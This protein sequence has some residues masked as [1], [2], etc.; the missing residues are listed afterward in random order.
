MTRILHTDNVLFGR[1]LSRKYQWTSAANRFSVT[2]LE[3][4]WTH[5]Q[6]DFSPS[7]FQRPFFQLWKGKVWLQRSKARNVAD[8]V[9]AWCGPLPLWNQWP[10][11]AVNG[12]WQDDTAATLLVIYSLWYLPGGSYCTRHNYISSP[13]PAGVLDGRSMLKGVGVLLFHA[14]R[15]TVMCYAETYPELLGTKTRGCS[16]NL[17][18]AGAKQTGG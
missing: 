17:W 2:N 16:E 5:T 18:L 15:S 1:L 14:K 8:N 9:A 13:T 7:N 11:V 3:F 12:S 4:E 6:I 10:R